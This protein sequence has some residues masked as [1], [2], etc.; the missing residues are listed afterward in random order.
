MKSTTKFIKIAPKKLALIADMVRGK[1]VK[2]A[3]AMLKFTPKK[4]AGIIR[5]SLKSTVANAENNL[6]QSEKNLYIY[7]ITATDGPKLKR[8][9]PV[10]RGR[11]HPI[12][13]RMSHLKIELKVKP[14]AA[15]AT[16]KVEK[17]ETTKEKP[18]YKTTKKI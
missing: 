7:S 8:F 18:T 17:A 12:L 3:M 9:I 16:K 11:T 14:E 2:S 13:K 6:K 1:D 15:V 4:A 5:K 10:S